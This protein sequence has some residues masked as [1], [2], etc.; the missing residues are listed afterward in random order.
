[1]VCPRDDRAL[2][3]RGVNESGARVTFDTNA[4][5]ILTFDA[6]RN[7][8]MLEF[9]PTGVRTWLVAVSCASTNDACPCEPLPML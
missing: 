2:V 1:G 5:Y 7:M 9:K 4:N 3:I 6:A 8:W